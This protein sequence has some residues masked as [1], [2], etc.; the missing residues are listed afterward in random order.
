MYTQ[1]SDI[2]EH[3]ESAKGSNWS[4]LIDGYLPVAVVLLIS[5]AT[6]FVAMVLVGHSAR[7]KR[8]DW[9]QK[10]ALGIR[11][12]ITERIRDYRVG[13]EF[14]RG[15]FDSSE[16]V[17]QQEWANFFSERMLEQ[18]FPGV[19]GF[20][21]VERVPESQAE[22]Y[23]LRVRAESEP[24]FTIR[25]HAQ[26]DTPRDG[27]D[28]F[29][30]RYHEPASRNSGAWGVDIASFSENRE[31]YERARDSG[32][33]C[34][35][36]P[37]RLL[38]QGKTMYGIVLVM[39]VYELGV[40][41]DT[42]ESRRDALVGWIAAPVGLER[43][44][45]LEILRDWPDF[46]IS[47]RMGKA[48]Q[49]GD[50][51]LYAS[52][53][54]AQAVH[55]RANLP[56]RIVDLDVVLGVT[57]KHHES[58]WITSRS[59]VAVL[60]S[61][62]LLTLML[63]T[64]TWSLTRTR[65]KAV[66]LARVMTSSIRQSEQ[67][68]RVLALQAA[69]ANKAKSE[70]LANM[71][72]EIRTPMTAILGYAD[73]LGD[74]VRLNQQDEEYSEAVQSIQRSGKHL[75]M[76]INDVLDLSKIES[77][78]L[79]VER[80]PCAIV[81]TVGEVYT[82]MRMGAMRKGLDFNI[83]FETPFPKTLVGDAY[84]VRQILLNLV[85]NA[86]KFTQSGSIDI[87]LN[88]DGEHLRFSV[89]DTGVGIPE[90][91][92]DALFDPFEQLDTSVSRTHEGTGL[93]L[94]ISQHLAHLM[95]GEIRVGSTLGV[96]SVF[97]L[98]LPRDCPEGVRVLESIE[99]SFGQSVSVAEPEARGGRDETGVILLAEDGLDNQRLITHLLRKAGYEIVIANN[100]QEAIDRFVASPE[101]FDLILMDMQMPVLDGYSATRKI[102]EMGYRV[103][104]IALT[105]H[106]LDGARKDCL[107]AGCDEYLTKPIDREKLYH[108]MEH[109]I[110]H[111]GRRAA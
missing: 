20:A 58:V 23:E 17:S 51:L 76:I 29:V 79:D 4:R 88:D 49:S 68:Q 77:G 108:V 105:A 62:G 99:E 31:A 61:G 93:G 32:E 55:E 18:N 66:E 85:G 45:E 6:W 25:D 98:V 41:T 14:G 53:N 89:I 59:T 9:L 84:R 54:D 103:P 50:R 91:S 90:D 34:A 72:H 38:Q 44:F 64:I 10:Q 92:V 1:R 46:D 24:G 109:H 80:Q 65:R 67:R 15:L 16:E 111:G 36:Q 101:R 96:G 97:T 56:M 8:V 35:T 21:F 94:T 11:E 39:P 3:S 42:I 26:A 52:N 74:L 40:E 86:V 81:E 47:L 37:L 19:W 57:S 75:M 69:S 83:R 43:L 110:R 63:T 78:K 73:V 70:F 33:I 13:I 5:L 87:V 71:S 102:R 107:D 82:T 28:L 12:T 48:G 27:R 60:I 104:I 22:A 95:G 2:P 30:I 100:G 106:A 7:E